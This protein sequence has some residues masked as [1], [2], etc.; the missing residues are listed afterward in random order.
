[1]SWGKGIVIAFISFALFIATLVTVCVKQ[2]MSL[3]S[4]DYYQEELDYQQQI[5]RIQNASTLVTRPSITIKNDTLRLAFDNLHNVKSGILKL[6][7]ASS[8][9]HDA[10]FQLPE[11]TYDEVTFRLSNLPRGRYKGS[12]Q[13]VMNGKEYYFDQPVDL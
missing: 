2:E 5:E 8:D 13:W 7:R 6:T 12:F 10:S 9:R 11:H 4:K 1:M 3:V